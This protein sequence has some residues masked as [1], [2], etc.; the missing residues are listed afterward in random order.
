MAYSFKGTVASV[1]KSLHGL[2][3]A[4]TERLTTEGVK[5]MILEGRDQLEASDIIEQ[6]NAYREAIR[7]SASRSRTVGD[8]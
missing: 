2:S 4:D 3:F 8:E 7:T 6:V 1:V 5:T